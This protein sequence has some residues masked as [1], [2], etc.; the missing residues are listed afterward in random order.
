MS[1]EVAV[2]E[3]PKVHSSVKEEKWS[4]SK[5]STFDDCER[6]YFHKYVEKRPYPANL[7]MQMGRIFHTAIHHV[8]QDGFSPVDA[9]RFAIYQEN[10][11]PNGERI[12]SVIWLLE[13]AYNRIPN[14]EV[15]LTSEVYLSIKTTLGIV[16]GYVDLIIDE[17]AYDS[18]Q[19]WDYKLSWTASEAEQSRQ[20]ALYGWMLKELRGDVVGSNFEGR[21]VF[22]R[23]SPD[24]DTAVELT[25]E[26]MEAAKQWLVRTIHRI[27]SKS[28]DDMNDWELAKDRK[29]CDY[30]PFVSLCASS[31][32]GE[33]FPASGDVTTQEEAERLGAYILAQDA[34][35]KQMKKGLREWVEKHEPVSVGNGNWFIAESQPNPKCDDVKGLIQYALEYGLEIADAVQPNSKKLLDWLEGDETG[36][37][38]Q[39]ISWTNPRRTLKFE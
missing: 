33:G 6:Q 17:P 21:L 22:P 24:E 20:L 8:I 28:L 10:G 38:E 35:I 34:A 39:L 25:E 18:T 5:L 1:T 31:I 29:K 30:C 11:L 3:N 15:E 9:A 4:Y 37:L 26:K 32:K 23:L 2:Q 13:R 12:Q 14:S 16:H 36:K 27:R 7:P 19:I